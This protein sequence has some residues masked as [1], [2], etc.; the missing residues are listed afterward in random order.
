[1][2]KQKQNSRRHLR[3]ASI[4]QPDSN[5]RYLTADAVKSRILCIEIQLPEYDEPIDIYFRPIPTSRVFALRGL[6]GDGSLNAMLEILSEFVCDPQTG[7]PLALTAEDWDRFGGVQTIIQGMIEGSGMGGQN[8]SENSDSETG[9]TMSTAEGDAM[10]QAALEIL[11]GDPEIAAAF[12]KAI[13][14]KVEQSREPAQAVTEPVTDIP[15]AEPN[16]D[17]QNRLPSG[18][19]AETH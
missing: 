1:M 8:Q 16:P 3:H 2:S 17:I 18:P 11:D 14:A 12:R 10:M 7:A 19:S 13:E 9:P 4:G 5:R 15:E 6:T